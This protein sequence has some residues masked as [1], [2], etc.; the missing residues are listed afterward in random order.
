MTSII[1]RHCPGL[2]GVL[3]RNASAF[4]PFRAAGPT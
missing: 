4:A 2:A 3:P 1:L